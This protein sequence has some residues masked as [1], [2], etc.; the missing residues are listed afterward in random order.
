MTPVYSAA[1]RSYGIFLSFAISALLIWPG[2]A[3]SQNV[4]RRFD[5]LGLGQPPEPN[6]IFSADLRGDGQVGN[7]GSGRIITS[8]D[9]G[10]LPEGKEAAPTD[11]IEARTLNETLALQID[12][13]P[14][15]RFEVLVRFADD[16][17]VPMLPPVEAVPRSTDVIENP[18][19]RAVLTTLREI[20]TEQ[21]TRA[22]DAM[23]S[24]GL[25]FDVTFQSRLLNAV[26]LQATGATIARM[27]ARADVVHIEDATR[28]VE[29][30][31]GNPD[32]DMDDSRAV[33][34]TD[35]Y[36]GQ[37]IVANRFVA[38]IDSGFFSDHVLFEQGL[39]AGLIGAW[40]C[41]ESNSDEL[42]GDND[43][44]FPNWDPDECGDLQNSHGPSVA[45]I[46]YGSN[47]LGNA[48]RG[49][50][51]LLAGEG[52]YGMDFFKIA[53]C[54][55]VVSTDA[56]E[57][58]FEAA[59][60]FGNEVINA[61]FGSDYT[62]LNIGACDIDFLSSLGDLAFDMGVAV[63][64]AT[65]NEANKDEDGNVIPLTIAQNMS[66]PA[67]AH[68]VLGIGAY[69]VEG[70][71][72]AP[73]D[74]SSFGPTGDGR[75]KPDL[76]GPSGVETVSRAGVNATD[77]FGGTS[78]ST[79]HV[80]AAA[81][82]LKG[83]MEASLA[84]GAGVIPGETISDPV[85]SPGHIYAMLIAMGQHGNVGSDGFGPRTGAG[86]LRL[87]S[88]GRL[89]FG[90]VEIEEG[91]TA[92][93]E[94]TVNS[95]LNDGLMAAAWWPES[96][97][98]NHAD[99]DLSMVSATGSTVA[100]SQAIESVFERV[101]TPFL[102]LTEGTWEIRVHGFDVPDEEQLVYLGIFASGCLSD[103]FAPLD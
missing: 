46:V 31:D 21:Q 24:D 72:G 67:C 84:S 71:L 11:E 40:D 90:S 62:S 12:A 81:I 13:N 86:A 60:L 5:G 36:V 48:F 91:E 70:N 95:V 56:I 92:S 101:R 99:I 82:L 39:D 17:R 14:D 8:N 32:N 2:V 74:A 102:S 34:R 103:E 87:R 49:V 1:W 50:A 10:L 77:T 80:S 43:A 78:A 19:R 4:D 25:D 27:A 98:E 58:A 100:T 73:T 37:G 33:M 57:L 68:K 26:G 9:P 6:G 44:L 93:F 75:T 29:M 47:A 52:G 15:D 63:F 51:P 42:C 65:G 30:R 35:P 53:D 88:C 59:T 79:P 76:M 3:L 61:S 28:R 54:D 20:R 69:N 41:V 97:G 22:I 83:V 55:D 23:R 94:L 7:F 38:V 66:S 96:P 16:L 89:W 85:V 18:E 64:A 45:G